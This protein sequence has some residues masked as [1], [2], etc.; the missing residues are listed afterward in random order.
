MKSK[1][2]RINLVQ[3]PDTEV[4]DMKIQ[5]PMKLFDKVVKMSAIMNFLMN[6]DVK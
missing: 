5:H 6:R 1:T 4:L 2:K 3:T